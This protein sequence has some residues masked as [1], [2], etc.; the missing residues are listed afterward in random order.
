MNLEVF[1]HQTG[2]EPVQY[3]QLCLCR[4]RTFDY[5]IVMIDSYTWKYSLSKMGGNF[6]HNQQGKDI[7]SDQT[8]L[9]LVL[10]DII[11]AEV[12]AIVNP[13]DTD[14]TGGGGL[15]KAIQ[16]AGGLQLQNACKE[17]CIHQGGCPTGKAVITNGGN[18]RAKYVIHTVGPVWKGGL[19]GEPILLA[20][21]YQTCLQ[22]AVD[23]GIQSVAFPS[24]STGYFKYPLQEATEVA[25]KVMEKFIESSE[26]VPKRIL[27]ILP[28]DKTYICY[29][30]TFLKLGFI[31]YTL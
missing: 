11:K 16:R 23:N 1:C 27:F 10:G 28:N 30:R 22:L 15:D 6:V 31:S 7:I 12:D 9:E 17:I 24:I 8:C 13:A 14:L 19:E 26:K 21:C 2:V 4:L 3:Q 29:V 20:S 18:L 5:Q 25:H